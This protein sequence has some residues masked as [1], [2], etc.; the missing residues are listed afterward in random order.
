MEVAVRRAPDD[1]D[2]LFYIHIMDTLNNQLMVLL[3]TVNDPDAPRYDIDVNPEGASTELGTKSRNIP[4]EI[5]ALRA[6][7]APGQV[8]R[9][10]RVLR[11]VMPQFES[12]VHKMG[13]D[14]F[15]V[16]P[17]TYANAITFERYGFSYIRGYTRMVEIHRQFQ[18]GGGLREKLDNSTP[19]RNPDHWRSVR[20][21]AWA[22][23]DGILEEPLNGLQMYKR[24]GKHAEVNTFPDAI[25]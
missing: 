23:H 16:E 6:G 11:R 2:P 12:F 25:W 8:R 24:V 15:F 20:G 9:G 13:H 18:P 22:I 17:L 14:I 7:L 3:A 21:R 10:L 1:L 19:F 5:A 4:A